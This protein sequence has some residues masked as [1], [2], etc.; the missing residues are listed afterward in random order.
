MPKFSI[1]QWKNSIEFFNKIK[2]NNA[3]YIYIS[4]VTTHE[5]AAEAAS[6]DLRHLVGSDGIRQHRRIH[7]TPI[8][9]HQRKNECHISPTRFVSA[10]DYEHW[11]WPDAMHD[12]AR[13]ATAIDAKIIVAKDAI[14]EEIG[15]AEASDGIDPAK[16]A[17]WK[18]GEMDGMSAESNGVM[19]RPIHRN[20]KYI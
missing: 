3:K 10:T 14:G 11:D 18:N 4:L 17:E 13:G 6:G 9:Q 19:S 15:S 20:H 1:G 2:L 8:R 7:R 12:T 16:I 5:G